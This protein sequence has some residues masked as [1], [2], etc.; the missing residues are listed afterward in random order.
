VSRL[1]GGLLLVAALC[2]AWGLWSPQ[3]DP[4][5]TAVLVQAYTEHDLFGPWGV[6]TAEA[7][8]ALRPWHPG[9]AEARTALHHIGEQR[10]R[11]VIRW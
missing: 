2:T 5:R 6:Q 7:A 9:Y 11:G 3:A 10:R 1:E 8:L 4:Q